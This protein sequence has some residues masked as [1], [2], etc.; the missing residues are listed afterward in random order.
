MKWLLRVEWGHGLQHNPA[1]LTHPFSPLRTALTTSLTPLFRALPPAAAQRGVGRRKDGRG[2]D[3]G[4]HGAFSAAEGAVQPMP[5]CPLQ[6]TTCQMSGCHTPATIGMLL[7][8]LQ[9][10]ESQ[11]RPMG[12]IAPLLP[13]LPITSAPDSPFLTS[14]YS[15]LCS[16][17]GARGLAMV[18]RGPLTSVLDFLSPASLS[19]SSSA[20][21]ALL[22]LPEALTS[23]LILTE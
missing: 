1:A 11:A 5:H 4:E 12:H 2:G 14:L 13:P 3:G 10:H 19:E 9:V 15:F 6:V 8:F 7:A 16:F 21:A 23:S 18:A 20:S 17:L 22:F